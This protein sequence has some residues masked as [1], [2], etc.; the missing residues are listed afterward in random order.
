MDAVKRS[1]TEQLASKE[2]ELQEVMYSKDELAE[3]LECLKEEREE[4]DERVWDLQEA[5]DELETE[6]L[7]RIKEAGTKERAK[8]SALQTE[9]AEAMAM[10][11]KKLREAMASYN[12]A[13]KTY[14]QQ[15]DTVQ[16][17]QQKLRRQE[18]EYNTLQAAYDKMNVRT[19]KRNEE[20]SQA[21]Q[22]TISKGEDTGRLGRE[23]EAAQMRVVRLEEVAKRLEFSNKTL[24]EQHRDLELKA[25]RDSLCH[26]EEVKELWAEKEAMETKLEEANT[27]SEECSYEVD[28]LEPSINS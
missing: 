8:R 20:L 2:Q 6:F 7:E 9:Q 17:L 11:D 15:E 14:E 16:Q 19:M 25:Q 5:K 21:R 18:E 13:L 4:M 3:E 27:R 26:Q 24:V 22:A 1:A 23:L 12:T 10:K 28:Q